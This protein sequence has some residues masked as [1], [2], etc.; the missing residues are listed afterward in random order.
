MDAKDDYEAKNKLVNFKYVTLDYASIPDNKVTLTDDDYKAITMSIKI[1][2]KNQQEL[3]SFDYV[4]F[5]A[6]PSK[7]DSAAIKEQVEKLVPD[8]KA[9]T[10][11]S[12]FVQINAETKTPIALSDIKA[13]LAIL[14]W[15]R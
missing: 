12:L 6:A 10:N 15:I 2:F 14:N 1:E 8:F 11:D 9:S 7:D 13:S 3:R 4:S 5:N